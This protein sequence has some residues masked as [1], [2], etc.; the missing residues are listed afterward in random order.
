MVP[1]RPV[2][3]A[4]LSV[5]RDVLLLP[6]GVLLTIARYLLTGRT[7]FRKFS[8]SL[9]G[10]IKVQLVWG[11]C[12]AMCDARFS[13][14]ILFY[15]LRSLIGFCG[16]WTIAPLAQKMP[17]YGTAFD[18]RA[19]W[20]VKQ[21]DAKPLDP[22]LIYL[23]GGGYMMQAAN[24]MVE[25]LASIYSLVDREKRGRLSVMALDYSLA[26]YG[27]PLPVQFAELE[28]TC[29]RL[30]DQGRTH[31]ILMGD[32]AGGHMSVAYTR[33][34][35][36]KGGD[37]IYPRK[38]ILVSPWVRLFPDKT[39]YVAGKAWKDNDFVD[40]LG[41][42]GFSEPGFRK[43]L[44]GAAGETNLVSFGNDPK[45]HDWDGVPTFRGAGHDV[46]VLIGEDE[47]FR[48]DV[49]R[50]AEAA[51]GVPF[52]STVKYGRLDKFYAKENYEYEK[53]EPHGPGVRLYVERNGV[54]DSCVIFESDIAA[55]IGKSAKELG[56]ADIDHDRYFGIA[57]IVRFLNETL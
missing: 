27:H 8:R 55:K 37:V 38:L 7:R 17:G 28:A 30:H 31:I 52:Y 36:S 41:Y 24:G 26:S 4:S 48:D 16:R 21:P 34:L 42:A 29:K 18:A 20:L 32:S 10:S 15:S 57:R 46:M 25:S 49:L 6:L 5:Y 33:H 54:H 44:L 3:M 13:R 23:H 50:W 51:L 39:D 35:R 14:L 56:V 53:K 9:V 40:I 2:R 43:T 12:R 47:V 19:T 22:V 45:P 1:A 11:Y